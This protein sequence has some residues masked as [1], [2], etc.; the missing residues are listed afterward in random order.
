MALW[1][2]AETLGFA[3]EQTLNNWKHSVSTLDVLK[4]KKKAVT[5]IV[6][7]D[8]LVLISFK[9]S[10]MICYY[11]NTHFLVYFSCHKLPSAESG[12]PPSSYFHGVV[13][14]KL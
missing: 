3:M 13:A 9:K 14:Q 1:P 10:F 6:P 11:K 2:I 7:A 4:V 12:P 8:N 5:P